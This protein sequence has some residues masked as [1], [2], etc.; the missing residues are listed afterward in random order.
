MQYD[1][2]DGISITGGFVYRGS[3]IPELFGKYVFGDLALV[4][5]AGGIRGSTAGCFTPIC[6]PD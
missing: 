2:G 5:A 6:R 3:G 4:P 1:H